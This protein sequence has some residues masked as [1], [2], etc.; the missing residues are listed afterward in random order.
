MVG[1]TRGDP[2]EIGAARRGDRHPV[3]DRPGE[4][5]G[6]QHV[7]GAEPPADQKRPAILQRLL[8]MAQLCREIGGGTFQRRRRLA[9]RT[10]RPAG[11]G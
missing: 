3:A 1:R 5:G 7:D 11:R 8:G 2:L 9:S 10:Q 4:A 6:E